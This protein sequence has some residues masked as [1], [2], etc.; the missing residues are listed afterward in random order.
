MSTKNTY[1]LQ[2]LT[3][4]NCAQK[5][6]QNIRAIESVEDVKVNFGAAKVAITGDVTIEQL[7]MAG[8]FDNITVVRE[9]ETPLDKTPF[10]KK[11]EN[12]TALIALAILLIG[13]AVQLILGKNH[14]IVISIFILSIVVGGYDLFKVGF[15]NLFSL[16]F[17]MKTLMT[18][19]IIGAA[20]IGEWVEGAIVILLF[21]LSEALESYSI[22]HARQSIQTLV[23]IAP[24]EATILQDGQAVLMDVA[25]IQ[26]GDIMLIKPG[27]KIAMDG[28]VVDGKTSVNQ[29]A[30]TGE[31]LPIH[32]TLSDEV[33][34]GTMNEEGAIQVK[35]TKLVEDTTLAK[36][37]HLVEEAQA[38]KAPAQHFI[39]QFAKYYTPAIMLLALF[40]ATVP[41][42][43][44][45][46]D[47]SKWVYLGLA[48]LVVGCPCA[49]IISTPVAIVTA[50]GN[51]AHHGVLIKGGAYLEEAGRI[52]AIAFDKTGTL[53][54]GKPAVTEAISFTN[55]DVDELLRIAAGIEAFSEHPLASAIVHEVK[56]RGLTAYE[57]RHFQSVTGKGA[58]AVVHGK[59]YGIGNMALFAE[60]N[61]NEHIVNQVHSL[62]Q[63]GQTVML[64]GSEEEIIGLIAVA[65]QVRT[66]AASVIERM[67]KYNLKHIF[68][69][70]GDNERTARAYAE[71]LGIT[72]VRADLL[73]EDKLTAIN[74]LRTTYGTVAMV[75][76]GVNDA[77]A[78]ASASVG[79]AMGSAG[80]D[81]ALETADIVLMDDDLEKLPF[82]ISLSRR[83]VSIIK[84]NI[85]F[86]FSLKI[87]ALALVIPNLLT[88]WIAIIADVGATLLVVLN[89]MRL[90]KE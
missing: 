28:V 67:K 43:L 57:A 24:N 30:I 49:L 44:V 29:A 54:V 8:A 84:Q 88:L 46:A 74:E 12:M 70:T 39:D 14:P 13:L 79:I 55:D 33:F 18:I 69:L 31:S 82:S 51:A 15:K 26:I 90:M 41:P 42:L 86:S 89:S 36:I 59:Q 64:V 2:G 87:V 40:V 17:D 58:T 53:T 71:Q 65:D 63:K 6:E 61:V 7:E 80:T 66:N 73:P 78:L 4:A 16:Y 83:T 75:G 52:K 9:T 34:A 3:C 68:M 10:W 81:A 20:I 11:R 23:S 37:I 48:T 21:A 32:K 27:E 22:D 62:Q 77:P 76:D 19:A 60:N 1:Q 5:F 56:N 50:I 25:D 35:V 85:I 45:G 47:W 72:D 38:E